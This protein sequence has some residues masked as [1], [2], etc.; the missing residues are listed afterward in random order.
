MTRKYLNMFPDRTACLFRS[1]SMA[2]SKSSIRTSC[3]CPLSPLFPIVRLMLFVLLSPRSTAY[4]ALRED[5]AGLDAEMKSLGKQLEEAIR[6]AE[7]SWLRSRSL[8]GAMRPDSALDLAAIQTTPVSVFN[9]LHK[10]SES[11]GKTMK[12][13]VE[14]LQ[15][16]VDGEPLRLLLKDVMLSS[17]SLLAVEAN[18]LIGR[19][20]LRRDEHDDEA[21]VEKEHAVEDGSEQEDD[22]ENGF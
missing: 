18:D 13:E 10:N 3:T 7:V 4:R 22:T 14:A 9:A 2:N 1:R 12:E 6:A 15:C 5:L 17:R 21:I 16:V 8:S 20:L 19:T 11:F